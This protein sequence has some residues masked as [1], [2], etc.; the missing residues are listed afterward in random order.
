MA[1]NTLRM[2]IYARGCHEPGAE[3]QW[4]G[5][6]IEYHDL[7]MKWY[8]PTVKIINIYRDIQT[9]EIPQVMMTDITRSYQETNFYIITI[10]KEKVFS[11]KSFK[12]YAL[13]KN[14]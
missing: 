13:F 10:N 3:C 9:S 6:A 14:K 1:E 5:I 11:R 4:L 12:F 8:A 2:V 7:I